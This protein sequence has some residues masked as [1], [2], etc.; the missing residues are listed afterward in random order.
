[1]YLFMKPRGKMLPP[2]IE[3]FIPGELLKDQIERLREF[4]DDDTGEGAGTE[5]KETAE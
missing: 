3:G 4:S 5:K 2:A 1:M